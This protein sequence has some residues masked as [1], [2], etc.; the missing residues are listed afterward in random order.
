MSYS[1]N[2]VLSTSPIS[3]LIHTDEEL[4]RRDDTVRR[5]SSTLRRAIDG[6][7]ARERQRTLDVDSALQLGGFLKTF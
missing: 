3:I 1:D 4:P 6:E 5:R 7:E 2:N